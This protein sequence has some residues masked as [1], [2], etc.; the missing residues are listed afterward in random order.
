MRLECSLKTFK[1]LVTQRKSAVS[2]SS[3]SIRECVLAKSCTQPM[4]G[5][6]SRRA[7][8]EARTMIVVAEDTT[9]LGKDG[10]WP[11]S[12]MCMRRRSLNSVVRTVL[13]SWSAASAAVAV[14]G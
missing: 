2:Y 7:G 3:K 4:F 11:V 9:S 5:E 8:T 6:F 10:L 14:L 12:T 13:E 1:A